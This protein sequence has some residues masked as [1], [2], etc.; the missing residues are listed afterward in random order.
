MTQRLQMTMVDTVVE[1]AR[2]RGLGCA[3]YRMQSDCSGY[4]VILVGHQEMPI[5]VEIEDDGSEA[6]VTNQL[7]PPVRTGSAHNETELA[8]L[9]D[10][11][12]MRKRAS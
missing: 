7:P 3:R 11:A 9:L 2:R 10:V 5:T 6:R 4:T 8:S 1:W 12:S